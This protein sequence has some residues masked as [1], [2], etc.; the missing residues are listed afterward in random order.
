MF[1]VVNCAVKLVQ[2]IYSDITYIFVILE[3]PLL[4]KNILSIKYTLDLDYPKTTK[5]ATDV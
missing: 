2:Y 3:K 5:A 4:S 1:L